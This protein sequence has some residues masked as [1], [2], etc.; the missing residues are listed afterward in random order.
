VARI[1]AKIEAS[2]LAICAPPP[3]PQLKRA[4][5]QHSLEDEPP[6]KRMKIHT[7]IFKYN[8]VADK[9]RN[10]ENSEINSDKSEKYS[11]DDSF[12]GSELSEQELAK[13]SINERK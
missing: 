5:A 4:N 11:D 2:K 6:A 10:S 13:K 9:P 3:K 7:N 8:D 1:L 12:D